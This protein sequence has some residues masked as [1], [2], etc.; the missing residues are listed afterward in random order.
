[1]G[2]VAHRLAASLLLLTLLAVTA[3]RQ[4][5]PREEVATP[6]LNPV[7]IQ[8]Q[9]RWMATCLGSRGR[10]RIRELLRHTHSSCPAVAG[11]IHAGQAVELD[12]RCAAVVAPLPARQRLLLGIRMELNAAS[13]GELEALPRIGPVLA[14]RI[15]AG[16]P[17]ASVEDLERV[18]GIGPK[19]VQLLRPFVTALPAPPAPAHEAVQGA[20]DDE[21]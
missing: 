21:G 5:P 12:P 11:W 9:G 7:G 6:C 2:T 8:Y 14:A 10:V 18:K 20:E 13:A 17:Y 3:W 16:R 1:M 4:R 19:T 15:V